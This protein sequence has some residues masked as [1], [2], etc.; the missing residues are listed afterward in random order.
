MKILIADVLLKDKPH[1]DWKEGYEFCYAFRNLGHECDVAGPHGNISELN[2]PKISTNYYLIIITENYPAYSGWKWWN[3]SEIKTPKL[4]WAIDTHLINFLPWLVES[5]IDYVAF[6]NPQDLEKYKL[7]NSFYMPYAASKIHHLKDYGIKKTKDI[8]FVGGLNNERRRICDKFNIE[9]IEAYGEDYV[10]SMQ[11]AKI[12]FNQSISYDINAK[13]FEIL[14]SGTFMLTNYNKYFHDFVNNNKDI[15]KMFY[16]SEEDLDQ[17]I[18]YYLS[19]DIEREA[20]A[21][22]VKSLIQSDHTW[23]NRATLILN[24]IKI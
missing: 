22:R 20:I 6:N 8:V 24:K 16:Y 5:K 11:S 13:Y 17:K 1:S 12:C 14:G 7:S 3:W 23:E 9:H 19:N 21:K 4:F 10:K 18:K 15:E 2:I